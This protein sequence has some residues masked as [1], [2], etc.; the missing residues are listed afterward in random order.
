MDFTQKKKIKYGSIKITYI[1]KAIH[2][3]MMLL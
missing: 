1:L 3:F 2:E